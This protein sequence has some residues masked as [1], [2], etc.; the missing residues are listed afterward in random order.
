MFDKRVQGPERNFAA[1]ARELLINDR[2]SSSRIVANRE[3]NTHPYLS[4]P[5]GYPGWGWGFIGSDMV[6]VDLRVFL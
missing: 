2:I 3:R 1:S 4:K 5:G 6:N